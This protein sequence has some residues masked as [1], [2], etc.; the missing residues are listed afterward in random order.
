MDED[1]DVFE[2]LSSPVKPEELKA[3]EQALNERIHAQQQKAQQRLAEL[4]DSNSTLPVTLSSINVVG[5]RRTRK[6]FLARIFNPLLSANHDRPYTLAEALR[7]VAYS[8]NQLHKFDIFHQPMSLYID[9][10]DPTLASS[11]PTDLVVNLSVREKSRLLLK[12][13]TDLGNTEGSAYGNLLWRNVF[14]GA[15]SLNVNASTGT[16]TRSAYSV[17]F[18]TPI[19]SNPDL[20]WELGGFSS[21]TQ[22]TWASHE[23]VLKGG[24]TKIRWATKGGDKHEIGYSGTW[25]QVTGLSATASPT[26]RSDAGDSVK[27]SISHTWTSDGRDNA[28]LPSRGVLLKTF[29]ELAGWGPLKGDVAFWK[30]EVETQAA[31]PIPFP[32]VKGKTGITFTTGFRAGMLY[33]MA[34]GGKTQAEPSHINDRF[35]LG[36]PTDVR[37]FRISGLGPRDGQDSVGGDVYAAGSAN[38]LF[39]LPRVSPDSPLRLQAFVNGGRLLALDAPAKEG[40]LD[41]EAV[42]KS[43]SS[44][45]AELANGLPSM[46]AGVGLVYAHPVARFELNFSLPLVIRQGE[47]GRKGLQFGVGIN[48]L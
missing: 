17:G 1:V 28:L 29:S 47:E 34:L 21:A 48:F 40:K 31:V 20:R 35:L 41:G 46:S 15:E 12:T 39:P 42:Q 9:K 19:L 2:R 8:A 43:A 22:K 37:G 11:T 4:I 44:T 18:E 38:L 6:D 24:E 10:P 5:A 30:S 33:P 3:R 26:V 14:G 16:R 27:S 25:R 23:E 36:G 13:G 7:E 32:G 45:V